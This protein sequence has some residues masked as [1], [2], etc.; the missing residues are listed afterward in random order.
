M[1]DDATDAEIIDRPFKARW[2]HYVRVH[3]GH[4]LNGRLEEGI[5]LAEMMAALKAEA[6]SS[7]SRNHD[8]GDGNQ[9]PERSLMQKPD[10][11]VTAA[12]YRWLRDRLDDALEKHGLIDLDNDQFDRPS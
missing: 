9:D 12:G 11:E 8:R 3:G 1:L 2:P 7:T 10:V 4:F 5:S 6:F